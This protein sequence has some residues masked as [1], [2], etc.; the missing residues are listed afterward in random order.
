MTAAEIVPTKETVARFM[1]AVKGK[2]EQSAEEVAASILD[3]VL[4]ATSAEELFGATEVAHARDWIGKPF[5]L[6]GLKFNES[7]FNGVGP[8]VY[9]VLE[10]VDTDGV[11]FVMTC[12]AL[13]VIA[14]AWRAGDLG[15][16]PVEVKITEAEKP[17]SAGFYPMDLELVPPAF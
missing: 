16:L 9:A 17:T 7:T 15:L 3:Q 11:P 4:S 14:K 6:R 12:G 5:V 8:D 13:K 10:C 2:T 1:E